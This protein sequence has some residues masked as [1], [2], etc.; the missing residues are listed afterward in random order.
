[1]QLFLET[2]RKASLP[3]VWSQGVKL[4]RDGAVT[5]V[6]AAGSAGAELTLRVRAPG[7]AVA[8]TVT[9]YVDAGEWSCDCDD[10]VDPC[11]HVT[12]AVIAS[13]QAAEKGE[14]LAGAPAQ[15]APPK[16]V[17]RLG[18]KDRLLT[19]SRTIIHGDGREE[20]FRESFASDRAR[21]GPLADLTPTHEDMRI[22]RLLGSPPREVVPGP[23]VG[24]LFEALSAGGAEVTF[25]GAPVQVSG[26]VI[27]P[28]ATVGDA[29]GGGF[30]LRLERDPSIVEVVA[31]GVARCKDGLHP[32]GEMNTTG[33]LLERLPLER[34]F[35][36]GDTAD[37]VTKVLPELEAKLDV[38]VT[39]ARLPRKVADARLRIAMDLSHQGHTLSVLPT[40]V[41]G[42]PPVARIDG[43]TMVALGDTVPVRRRDHERD[44]LRRLRDELHL[45]PGR[46]V[47]LDG[48][49]AIR[50]ATKLREWQKR[51]GDDGTGAAFES[52]PLRPRL[53]SSPD[54]F[55]VLFE[56][57]PGDAESSATPK[58][59]EAAAVLRAWRDGLELVPLDGGGWAPL[60]AG[61]LAQ[62]GHLVA[63]LLA[64]RGSDKKLTMAALPTAGALCDVLDHPR[65]TELARLAPL[66]E[67]FEG[68][69]RAPLPDGL[70]ATL[71]GY[72]QHG[73]DWLSFLRD[74]QLGGILADDMG[75]GKTLQTLCVLRGRTL[76]VCPK[77][78]VYNWADEIARFR[79]GLRAAIYHGPRRELDPTA[80][81]T[82]T[83]YAILRLDADRLA[84]ED[85][86]AVVL[87]EA[88]AIKNLG[89]QTARAAFELH[90]KFRIALSGTPVENRLEELWSAMHFANPGLLGGAGDFQERYASPIEAGNPEAASR[91]RAKIRPFILRRTKAEVV[92]ELPSRTD[93]VLHVELDEV[94]R[95]V[96][97]A[98]RVAT[99]K[100]VADQMA[101][102]G[103]VLA[104][105]E[106]L[107]R[108]R[109]AACHSALVP[110]QKA[111]SSSKIERLL[112]ALEES[113]A[114]GHKALVFSQWTSL[115][116]KVEPALNAAGIK[117]T[118]LDGSTNDRGAVVKEFQDDAGPPVMLVSL[119]AG[120]TGLNLTA[121]DHVFLLDPWWNPAVED[122]AASRAHRIGQDR[123]V[124][125][126]RMVAKDTVEERIL[127]LQD[128]KRRIADVALGDADQAA[129]ITRA[130]LLALLD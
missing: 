24:D 83:T 126:H 95:N 76:V 49:E 21:A 41:Y 55:D 4:A 85:W 78:V 70:T 13:A 48:S 89:S 58:R 6:T 94:E 100:A 57:E 86:D 9:L 110:G 27:L 50:F 106:A 97:D 72:Q 91:L 77:S 80:E 82:L 63:D 88:Q 46:R 16:L 122:Q 84:A 98:V 12:A 8:P 56:C 60:P 36:R 71:R 99:K 45:V 124:M 15:A 23:R 26:D 104:A 66:F 40:L 28:R 113:V 93:M 102:G 121:A 17:Y 10:K 43:D 19:A 42:D 101:Q 118:R 68:I 53:V 111:D 123:P 44:M 3:G 128:R 108:L 67:G 64:A 7:R 109:Q 25:D 5:A 52:A 125:V 115:L 31:R 120:G 79:P 33:E 75:L 81:V 65:P 39:T 22:D 119:K 54:T 34:T 20:R 130:E 92:P 61:W 47:D 51:L 127:S 87:D 129:G 117:F 1:M 35:A 103:G 69:P 112:E 73:V 29:P 59:A 38:I 105:L 32:L 96:Y 62:H 30:H 74:A 14:P 11:M 37:L 18:R 116:D 2:V 114:E 107:L 90:G